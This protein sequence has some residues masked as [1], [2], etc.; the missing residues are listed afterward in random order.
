MRLYKVVDEAYYRLERSNV[1]LARARD[2]AEEAR[3]IKQQFVANVSHELRTPLNIIIGFSET[4]ALSPESYGV[5]AIPGQLM[6]DINRIYRSAR[7][8]K[9]LIDD[10]LDLSQIDARHMPL[11]I[12]QSSLSQIILEATDMLRSIVLRKGLA[13]TLELPESLPPVLLD[14]LRIRQV[15]LNL[16]SNAIRF[17]DAGGYAI[18]RARLQVEEVNLVKGIVRRAFALEHEL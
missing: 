17:T 8:L 12:E 4:L 6:G 3:R 14:R 2:E 11:I 13:L 5:R 1:Q 7:H 9:S 18:H 15:L 10:V 16:L